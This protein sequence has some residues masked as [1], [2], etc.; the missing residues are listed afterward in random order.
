MPPPEA[1]HEL[2]AHRDGFGEP[3]EVALPSAMPE[4]SMAAAPPLA[5][6]RAAREEAAPA[7]VSQ[8]SALAAELVQRPPLSSSGVMNVSSLAAKPEPRTF[9]QLL[10]ASIALGN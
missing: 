5:T 2:G 7:G 1:E 9:L 6:M 10:D 4:L 8:G 3:S